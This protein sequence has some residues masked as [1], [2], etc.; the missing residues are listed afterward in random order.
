MYAL[1][2]IGAKMENGMVSNDV[3]TTT[4]NSLHSGKKI[5]DSQ[6]FVSVDYLKVVV[7]LLKK[8][9]AKY[10]LTWKELDSD[11]QRLQDMKEARDKT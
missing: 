1:N 11:L 5:T 6:L 8:L 2:R 7:D 3:I 9:G 10:Y 4:L